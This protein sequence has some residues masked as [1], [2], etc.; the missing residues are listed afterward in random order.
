MSCG[1]KLSFHFTLSHGFHTIETFI[2][3]YNKS[4]IFNS[5]FPSFAPRELK[6]FCQLQYIGDLSSYSIQN[7]EEHHHDSKIIVISEKETMAFSKQ[8]SNQK[9]IA[10]GRLSNQK[11]GQAS[12]QL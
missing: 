8:F 9:L 11:G 3:A 1:T 7:D 10:G 2:P 6:Q 5:Q 4:T 12:M